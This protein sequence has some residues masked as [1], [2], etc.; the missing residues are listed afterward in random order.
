MKQVTAHP[1]IIINQEPLNPSE[2][3]TGAAEKESADPEL[4]PTS[5]LNFSEETYITLLQES[6]LLRTHI[7]QLEKAL[8]NQNSDDDGKPKQDLKQSLLMA[9]ILPASS[10]QLINLAT[11]TAGMGIWEWNTTNNSIH[12]DKRMFDIYGIPPTFDG[13]VDYSIWKKCV[14]PEELAEQER[15]LQLLVQGQGG[16]NR[17]F[18]IRRASDGK[19][20]LLKAMEALYIDPVM[21]TQ[22][23]LGTNLDITEKAMAETALMESELRFRTYIKESSDSMILFKASGSIMDSNKAACDLL[24]YSPQE[25]L[26]MNVAELEPDSDLNP[27]RE[28]WRHIEPGHPVLQEQQLRCKNKTL[29]PVEIKMTCYEYKG[30]KDY[31]WLARDIRQRKHDE[32]AIKKL[33]NE[34]EQRVK[35]RTADLAAANQ[36]L[37]TFSYSVSHDLR[38]PLRSIDGFSRVLLEDYQDKLDAA[39]K[40][41]LQRVCAASQRMG[42]LISDL[43]ELSKISRKEL[44]QIPMNFSAMVRTLAD[45]LQ[46]QEPGRK[47]EFVIQPEIMG[48]ADPILIRVVFENLLENAWKFTARQKAPRIEFGQTIANGV[49]AFFVRDNGAGFDM[50]YVD[51]LFGAFQRLHSMEDFPGTGIGLASVQRILRR[52]GGTIWAEGKVNLGATFYFTLPETNNKPA[53]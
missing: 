22:W 27:S 32:A 20:L 51:K 4:I 18:H 49:S 41:S 50:A 7:Y 19:C 46:Q 14:L 8:K 15:E 25:L 44:Y 33:N 30:E 6:A 29:V 13:L 17:E 52:H 24:G 1:S 26:T 53:S 5:L 36:E 47:V 45:E 23:V 40:D 9:R 31:F 21:G 38:A 37:E 39:G 11:K 28:V 16:G 42:Q 48:T 12:W 3:A 2:P 35:E 34:L 10:L 43:L